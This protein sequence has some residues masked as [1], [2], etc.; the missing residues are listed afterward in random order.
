MQNKG[1]FCDPHCPFLFFSFFLKK[2]AIYTT[3]GFTGLNHVSFQAPLNV[4]QQLKNSTLFTYLY[5]ATQRLVKSF[6][7]GKQLFRR[8][9]WSCM[10]IEV[11]IT[12]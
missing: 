1:I 12:S 9:L 3:S 7:W 6:G 5:F 8:I 11:L 10:L 4:K 2:A